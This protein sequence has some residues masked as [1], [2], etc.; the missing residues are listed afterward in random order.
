M[1][2][3]VVLLAGVLALTNCQG[4]TTS[5]A[6]FV[7]NATNTTVTVVAG[8][9]TPIV[10]IIVTLSTGIDSST[11]PPTPTGVLAQLPT[12]GQGA[13]TF[14]G[15]PTTGALCV[16]ASQNGTFVS[17]CHAPFPAT[18]TLTFP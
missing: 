4:G 16:S 1:R 10:G 12:N 9:G 2:R 7:P 8:N 13:T 17:K 11:H 6:N 5:T 3:L 18:V 15:L 14:A